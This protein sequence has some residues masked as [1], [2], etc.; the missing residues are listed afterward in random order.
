MSK[1]QNRCK[2][3]KDKVKIKPLRSGG[4][5]IGGK[6]VNKACVDR[7]YQL[8]QEAVNQYEKKEKDS[9]KDSEDCA[10]E[11]GSFMVSRAR[12]RVFT[13]PSGRIRV[14]NVMSNEDRRR[15]GIEQDPA[16][17]DYEEVTL[18]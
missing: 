16:L 9:I 6:V 7:G 10:R 5:D 4:Y 8:T 11:I 13:V 15:M 14:G 2:N 3:F 12:G 17:P 1:T 18:P